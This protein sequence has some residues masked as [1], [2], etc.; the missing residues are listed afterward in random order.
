MNGRLARRGL[1]NAIDGIGG[2]GPVLGTPGQV[3]FVQLND[4]GVDA[5]DLPREHLRN[6]QRQP[7]EIPIMLVQDNLGEHVGTGDRQLQ[8]FVGQRA[9]PLPVAVQI[10]Q[11]VAEGGGD[12]ARGTGAVGGCAIRSASVTTPSAN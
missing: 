2:Q 6:R 1:E 10:E 9:G 12:D 3:R 11:A 4:C 8:R 5:A 7:L